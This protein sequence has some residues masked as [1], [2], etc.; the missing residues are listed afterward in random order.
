[1]NTLESIHAR[2]VPTADRVAA[3]W[4][5]AQP[6]TRRAFVA[7]LVTSAALATVVRRFS[8]KSAPGGSARHNPRHEACL[9]L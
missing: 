3:A 5:N 6:I 7:A 9:S 2:S 4:V 8:E 1:M